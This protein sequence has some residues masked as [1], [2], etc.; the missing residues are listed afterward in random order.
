MIPMICDELRERE[1]HVVTNMSGDACLEI[2]KMAVETYQHT[3]VL[4]GSHVSTRHREKVR[5]S[6]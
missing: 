1:C 3:T 2:V 6:I 4:T 5:A